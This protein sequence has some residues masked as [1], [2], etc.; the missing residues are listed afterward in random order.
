M[1]WRGEEGEKGKEQ[2]NWGDTY[3]KG[4]GGEK[5]SGREGGKRKKGEGWME[6]GGREE[7][8]EGR[9]ERG[10]TDS[11]TNSHSKFHDLW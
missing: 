3:K 2:G 6:E 11:L 1:V 8:N 10:L 5:E 4:K 7:E 9:V